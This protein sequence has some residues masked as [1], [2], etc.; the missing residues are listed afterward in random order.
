M[1]YFITNYNKIDYIKTPYENKKFCLMVNKSGLNNNIN[2]FADIMRQIGEVNHISQ[3]NDIIENDSCYNSPKLLEVF[4]K[5]K[6]I[7]CFEN[8]YNDGYITEKIFNCLFADTIPI[9]SGSS[10]IH[11]FINKDCFINITN[12]NNLNVPI[13]N[14]KDINNNKKLFNQ[15]INAPK[16]SLNYN[17][18]NFKNIYR[19][20]II[21]LI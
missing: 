21:D 13:Q 1:N 17:D 2:K 10:I 14:I 3:Y 8:S 12:D 18:M 11:N 4:N 9:Y 16:V 20:K 7:I 5:Y 6:F 19:G 15:Y